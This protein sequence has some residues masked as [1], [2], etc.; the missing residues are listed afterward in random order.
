MSGGTGGTGAR[1]LISGGGTVGHLAPGFALAEALE[2]RGVPTRF[3]T[4]GASEEA[5]W[6]EGRRAPLH[7]AAERLPRRPLAL[8]RF[9]TR[10][11]ARA[12]AAGTVLEGCGAEVL[13]ALGGWPCVPAVLAARRR[14][15]PYVFLVPDEVP[16][17]V[18]RR[19]HR[20][21]A[22]CYV[23]SDEA[24]RRLGARALVTGPLLR[25][26]VVQASREP[27]R[28]G[29]AGDRATLLVTGGSLGARV[30][31]RWVVEG[32]T[33]AADADPAALRG[34]QVLHATG[35]EADEG[36]AEAYA[37]LGIRHHV[38]PFLLAMGAAYALA[39]LVIGRAGAGTCAELAAWGVPAVL[40][41]YP[42]HRDRQQYRNAARLEATGQALVVEQAALTPEVFRTHVLG[43]LA[44]PA[45]AGRNRVP[46]VD[47][48]ALAAD[49]LIRLMG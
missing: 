44:A 4:P 48:A 8:L 49:D 42:H 1:V 9:L 15:L 22:R 26:D 36:V 3:A 29:L 33:A 5:R 21:A 20:R 45:G 46:V 25:R 14:G 18:V 39:D 12:R 6:F 10:L 2:A 34:I 11:R 16:G 7:I 23:A 37:R 17:L 41:P 27:E 28:F 30:I 47:G 13:V 19:Y 24:A 35:A 40:V 32:L 43:R 38:T 31:N